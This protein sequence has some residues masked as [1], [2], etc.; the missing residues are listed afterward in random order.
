MKTAL[1]NAH[2]ISVIHKLFQSDERLLYFFFS[3]KMPD[4]RISPSQLRNESSKFSL[5][6]RLLIQVA[7]D[8]WC[9]AGGTY[10]LDLLQ[11][12]DNDHW[13]AFIQAI[14]TLRELD[15]LE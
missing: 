14:A 5:D 3:H 11:G 15:N 8:I 6:E 2:L 12:W 13:K 7:L 4:L 10:F 1:Q 9:S